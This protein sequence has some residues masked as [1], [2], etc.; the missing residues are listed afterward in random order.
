MSQFF[1]FLQSLTAGLDAGMF[2]QLEQPPPPFAPGLSGALEMFLHLTLHVITGF[3]SQKQPP[4]YTAAATSDFQSSAC[5][6]GGEGRGIAQILREQC[7]TL[8]FFIP[9]VRL[10]LVA[11]G[12]TATTGQGPGL[13]ASHRGHR[14]AWMNPASSTNQKKCQQM[15]SLGMKFPFLIHEPN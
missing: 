12:D 6:A 4:T 9:S 13:R 14:Q 15:G 11:P 10:E 1:A 3:L 8:S 7:S 5:W 2:F